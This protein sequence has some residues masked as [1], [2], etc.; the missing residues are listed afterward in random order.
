MPLGLVVG[1]WHTITWKI[2]KLI[3]HF[4]RQLQLEQLAE[5][6][7]A[8]LEHLVLEFGQTLLTKT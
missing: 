5:F 1:I 3:W 7:Q 8:C 6:S 2:S 4:L